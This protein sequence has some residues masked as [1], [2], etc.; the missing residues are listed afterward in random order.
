MRLR[1]INKLFLGVF[2]TL[3]TLWVLSYVRSVEIVIRSGDSP[4]LVEHARGALAVTQ[5]P[6]LVP[7]PGLFLARFHPVSTTDFLIYENKWD[8]EASTPLPGMTKWRGYSPTNREPLAV[9]M[10]VPHMYPAAGILSCWGA[11]AIWRWR[12]GP[13]AMFSNSRR[14]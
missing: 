7:G 5:S 6:V 2:I 9:G 8:I 4:F 11:V 14:R 10:I 3:I 12:L 13:A 1:P